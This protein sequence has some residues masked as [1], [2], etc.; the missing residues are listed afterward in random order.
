VGQEV[1]SSERLSDV[2]S[3]EPPREL[4]AQSQFEAEGQPS[5]G[6]DGCAVG[7][8]QIVIKTP[9]ALWKSRGGRE[10]NTQRS[11]P[12]SIRNGSLLALSVTKRRPV[13]VVQTCA[14]AD[15]CRVSW[16]CSL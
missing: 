5:V 1:C 3:H 10:A 6:G 15:I 13:A 2:C 7:S 8:A 4:L 16:P 14:T 12:M 11:E 9:P